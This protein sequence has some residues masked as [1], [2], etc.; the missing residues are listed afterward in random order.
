MPGLI[1]L[2]YRDNPLPRTLLDATSHEVSA[3]AVGNMSYSQPCVSCRAALP[4]PLGGFTASRHDKITGTR[5][6]LPS[7]DTEEYMKQ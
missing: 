3:L 7:Q 5:F 2:H 4:A 6:S 1:W